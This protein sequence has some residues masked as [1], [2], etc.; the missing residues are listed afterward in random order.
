MGLISLMPKQ[1]SHNFCVFDV[2]LKKCKTLGR[3][4]SAVDHPSPLDSTLD[5][6]W[7]KGQVGKKSY[8]RNLV[9]PKVN[10]CRKKPGKFLIYTSCEK[11]K[12]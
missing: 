7:L 1:I 12:N 4:L 6:R 10:K 5:V 2:V 11:V 9:R 3:D 8:L